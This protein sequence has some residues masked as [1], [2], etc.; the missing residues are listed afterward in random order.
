MTFSDWLDSQYPDWRGEPGP[1]IRLHHSR[2]DVSSL[3]LR[4][5]GSRVVPDG[6]GVVA[7]FYSVFDGA[8]LFSSTFKVCSLENA[9]SRGGVEIVPSLSALGADVR[10]AGYLFPSPAI[11]FLIQAGIGVYAASAD[12][13]KIY[14]W[15]TEEGAVSGTYSTLVEILEEWLAAVG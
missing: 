5:P 1:E 10:A 8:D 12:S 15:D 11:P 2:G 14:E 3:W 13:S 6:L 9:K 4:R 7:D